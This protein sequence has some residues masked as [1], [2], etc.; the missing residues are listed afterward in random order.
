MTRRCSKR[1]ALGRACVL[2]ALAMGAL[3]TAAPASLDAQDVPTEI[4]EALSLSAA[5]D[6]TGAIEVV[7]ALCARP[8]APEAAFGVLGGL[9]V[10]A[11]EPSR[12]LEILQPLIGEETADPGV[13]YN[14]GRAAEALGLLEDAGRHYRR[15]LESQPHSP[16]LRSLG[17][18]LGR[19]GYP[20]E[21]YAFLKPWTNANPNDLEARVAAVA[22]AIALERAPE[23]ETLL[24]GLP[25]T[26]P[27]V[28]M[29][30]A[31]LLLQQA[32]PWGAINELQ[33]LAG[34]VPPAIDGAV[35]RTLARAYLVV[36]D[37][38]GALEQ[39]E[40]VDATGPEDAVL[41]ASA[42]FQAGRLEEAIAE[43]APH[44]EPLASSPVPGNAPVV[45]RDI[46]L[47][48]GRYLHSHGEAGRAVPF[49]RLATELSPDE[50]GAL[51]ALGQALAASGKRD[52]AREVL[53]RFRVL[54]QAGANDVASV[55]QQ[56]EDI[57]DPT[58]R[59]VRRALKL[60]SEGDIEGALEGLLREAQL[61]PND[62][63]PAYGASSILLEAGRNEE[64]LLAADQALAMAPGQADGLYQRGAVLMALDR[65]VEAEDMFR[66]ALE[67]QPTH[68][69]TL[70][71]YAVLL[72]STGRNGAARSPLR[73]IL[74]LRPNDPVAKGHLERLTAEAD[75]DQEEGRSHADVGRELLAARNFLAAEDPLRAAVLAEA[76][77]AALRIDLATVLWENNKPE[78]AELH[79]REAAARAPSAAAAHRLLGGLLLWRGKHMEAAEALERATGLADPDAG[80]LVDLA[81]AWDGAA[82][83][84]SGTPEERTWLTRAEDAYRRAL[85]QASGHSEAV[86]GHAQVLRRL[87]RNEEAAAKMKRYRELYGED[88]RDTRESGRT[89]AGAPGDG[90]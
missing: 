40:P 33:T 23:A 3:L 9:Y 22:G 62:P 44:A 24:E 89:N 68:L 60:A 30:R 80:L 63:R 5:G 47:E 32:D 25:G 67:A 64:A 11:G 78:E 70:S 34:E 20:A 86:Y 76:D 69:A 6:L 84:V 39:M 42:Y 28:K 82:G 4:T 35:R 16:A 77:D 37:A 7:E 26:D 49:L 13:L 41:L 21:A 48:Y 59:E 57:A 81:R 85:E 15:S 73:R 74:E 12:A 66:Q 61:T 29:L 38:E 19:H 2:T 10:E 55:N 72:M 27:G 79:A 45:T 53:E 50:P 75:Q 51:Q 83:D 8:D 71:D 87:G 31:Q 43:L 65:L 14:A 56:R 54:S 17:M 36:G 46:V 52:E 90:D 58:G 18:M 88:Q 1:G